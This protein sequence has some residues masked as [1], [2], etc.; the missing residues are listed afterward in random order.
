MADEPKALADLKDMVEEKA[1]KEAAKTASLIANEETKTVEATIK[2]STD[3]VAENN[4][5]T[6]KK[7]DSEGRS[8]ATG[9]RKNAIARVW[10]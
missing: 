8:Y 5:A 3:S 1:A 6:E 9:K 10:I 2:T 4:V 7:I